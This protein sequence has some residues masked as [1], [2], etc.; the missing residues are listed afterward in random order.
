[1]KQLEWQIQKAIHVYLSKALPRGSFAWAVDH[2]Q[3]TSEPARIG[4]AARGICAGIPDH[5]VI[6]QGKLI[7]FEIKAPGNYPTESQ[8]EFGLRLQNAQAYWF[9]VRSCEEVEV[10]LR[11]IGV[12][13]NATVRI[14]AA[15]A[16]IKKPKRTSRPRAKRDN[17]AAIR[18]MMRPGGSA[19]RDPN[20]IKRGT[21]L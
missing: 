4:M 10:A 12:Q 1:V 6:H 19:D 21:L 3:K 17:P 8:R 5:M 7:T 11:S 13:L 9:V 2:A 16:A 15:Q 20:L 18:R 14:P